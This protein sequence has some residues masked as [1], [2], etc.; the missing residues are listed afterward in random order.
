MEMK[1][2]TGLAVV[3]V[4]ALLLGAVHA[5]QMRGDR[6]AEHAGDDLNDARTCIEREPTHDPA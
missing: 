3:A 4:T 1:W 2:T 5:N 6:Q